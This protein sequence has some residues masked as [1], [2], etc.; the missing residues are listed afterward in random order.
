MKTYTQKICILLYYV[1]INC[2]GAEK[3]I[4]ETRVDKTR[5]IIEHDHTPHQRIVIEQVLVTECRM[6]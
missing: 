4:L 2:F 3:Q 6:I 1:Y 5:A